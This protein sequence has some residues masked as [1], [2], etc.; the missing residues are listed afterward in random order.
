[1]VIKKEGI[2]KKYSY[3]AKILMPT[4]KI[5]RGL[6]NASYLTIGH[7]LSIVI[8][9]F[10]FIFIARLLG[11]SDYGIYVAVAA[12]VG[13]FNIITFRGLNKTI[14]R[15]GAKDLDQMEGFFEKTMGIKILFTSIAIIVCIIISF[16]SPYSLQE[17]FYIIIFSFTLIYNSFN[18]FFQTVFQ[19]TEKMQYNAALT[20]LNR[21]LFVPLSIAFLYMGFGLLALF[22]ISLFSHFFTLIINFR[23]TKKF[24]IFKFWNKIK[25]DKSI[26]RPALIFSILSF[27]VLLTTKIDVVM[28]SWLSTPKDVGIYGVAYQITDIGV[29]LRGILAIAFFPIFV[30]TFH[31]HIV[32]W[33]KLFKYAFSLGFGLLL[34]ATVGALLSK[35]VITLLFGV[36]YSDSGV[37]LSVLIFYMVFIFFT[38][39]FSNALQAT[40]NEDKLLKV[41][42][43][44]PCLNIGLNYLFFKIFGLIGIAYSTLVVSSV[45]IFIIVLITWR[46]LKKQ[47]KII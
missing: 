14:L 1:V 11:P 13:L 47:K 36:A 19:A 32:G 25:W 15:E 23:L 39:P 26:L 12:F 29:T 4:K 44:G 16:V 5:W 7:F 35:Q 27:T 31:K 22:I 41:C 17:R 30:K 24:L 37:I 34:L 8:N 43:I 20:I 46:T 6:K 21:I 45:S 18:G 28:V 40:H 10:G 33:K 2:M 9:F 42:W 38:I 3:I